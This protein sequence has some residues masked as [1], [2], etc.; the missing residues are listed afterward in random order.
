MERWFK[1]GE[2]VALREVWDGRLFY[3][4]PVTVVED[5]PVRSM[6]YVPPVTHS[7]FSG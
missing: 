6:F 5:T 2:T 7:T 4:R 3:V 1:S